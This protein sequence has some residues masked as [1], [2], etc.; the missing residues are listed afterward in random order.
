MLEKLEFERRLDLGQ[1]EHAE[2]LQQRHSHK[3][4]ILQSVKQVCGLGPKSG[5]LVV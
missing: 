2:L 3:D 5:L 1:R 4:E